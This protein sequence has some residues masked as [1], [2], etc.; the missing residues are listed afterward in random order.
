MEHGRALLTETDRE[1]IAK[2]G[3]PS[4]TQR[5]QAISRVRKRINQELTKDLELLRE[6]HPSLYEEFH[7]VACEDGDV[8]E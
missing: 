1:Y 7:E 5:Y 6:H 4:E 2:E 8:D 3:N